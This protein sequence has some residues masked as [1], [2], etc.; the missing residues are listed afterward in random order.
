MFS[1]IYSRIMQEGHNNFQGLHWHTKKQEYLISLHQIN[2]PWEQVYLSCSAMFTISSK[3]SLLL[4]S[5]KKAKHI[6]PQTVTL[7]M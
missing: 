5:C 1:T 2:N 6:S 4:D 3:H 7:P